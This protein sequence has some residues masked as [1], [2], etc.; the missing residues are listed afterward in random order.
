MALGVLQAHLQRSL[1]VCIETVLYSCSTRLHPLSACARALPQGGLARTGAL[2][3][4]GS[5]VLVPQLSVA[6]IVYPHRLH[7]SKMRQWDVFRA[8]GTT[9]DISA[10][11]TMVFAVG[12]GELLA[13]SHADIGIGPFRR[14]RAVEHAAGNLLPRWEVESFVL[15]CSVAFREVVQ[16]V[17]SLRTNS[18]VLDELEHLASNLRVASIRRLQQADQVVH[19]LPAGDLLHKV[20]ASIL[21]AGVGE[22]QRGE[23]D[24]GVL[25]A[26]AALQAAHGLLGLDCLAADNVGDLQVEGDVFERTGGCALDLSIQLSVT[27]A[28]EPGRHACG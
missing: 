10:V 26:Y 20:A 3:S 14:C 23:L 5:M 8:A 1:E 17:L 16:A 19:E 21:D 2:R 6:S 4:W 13:T 22:I 25:V 28:A 15:Q 12:E 18:P 11:A 7:D 24:V 27:G 9:K